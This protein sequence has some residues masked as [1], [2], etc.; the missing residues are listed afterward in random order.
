MAG[1]GL[2]SEAIGTV[3]KDLLLNTLFGEAYL[4]GILILL[5]TI[6]WIVKYGKS[7]NGVIIVG[8]SAMVLW[9]G[10][11]TMGFLNGGGTFTNAYLPNWAGT[12]VI[13]V[14]LALFAVGAYKF[15]KDS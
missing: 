7:V 2:S 5:I 6:I 1:V 13:A 15:W 4:V 12:I 8:G 11:T 9:L 14:C 10:G 3:I